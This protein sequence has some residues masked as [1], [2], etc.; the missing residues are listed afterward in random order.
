MSVKHAQMRETKIERAATPWLLLVATMAMV[1]SALAHHTPG[2]GIAW[3]GPAT[4]VEMEASG[5]GFDLGDRSGSWFATATVLEYAPDPRVSFLARIPV[6]WIDYDTGETASGLADIE[7]G[8]KAKLMAVRENRL[9][10]WGGASLELPTGNEAQG[11]GGGHVE[12]SPHLIASA[13]PLPGLLIHSV[14]SDHFSLSDGDDPEGALRGS[15]T[16]PGLHA[17]E[18][19]D[20]GESAVHGSVLAPHTDHE[21]SLAMVAVYARGRGYVSAGA[22]YIHP[23]S[24]ST[25][26]D[27]WIGRTEMG[28]ALP[29]HLVLSAGYDAPLSG[30]ERFEHR[31]RLALAWQ[32]GHATDAERCDPTCICH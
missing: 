7:L 13:E 18:G 29:A 15:F 4:V 21:L 19:H 23:W 28:Y 17:H 20:H 14:A 1:P 10:F 6:A 16:A 8:G 22:E 25:G 24:A 31:A 5:A 11:L 32:L 3:I 12:L 9:L 27:P 30:E 26:G 2:H